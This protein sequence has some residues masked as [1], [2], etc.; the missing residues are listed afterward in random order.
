[1]DILY[2]I[3]PKGFCDLDR[4]WYEFIWRKRECPGC[5]T[6]Y[7][8]QRTKPVDV[9]VATKPSRAV[10]SSVGIGIG[11]IRND[12]L[13]LLGEDARQC[14]HIGRVF[15]SK[16]RLI[17]EWSTF[18]GDKPIEIRGGPGS[19]GRFCEQCGRFCYFAEE[20]PIHIQQSSLSNQPI[21]EANMAA[22]LLAATLYERIRGKKWKGVYIT[23]LP[24]YDEPL[25]GIDP[26]PEHYY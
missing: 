12:F 15:D 8:D 10:V 21:Y 9:V 24:I 2:W 18:I 4:D 6:M 13:Q 22:I 3:E 26:F 23:R 17:R 14:L 11:L 25:D 7:A 16:T 19:S 1:M 20:D 5:F